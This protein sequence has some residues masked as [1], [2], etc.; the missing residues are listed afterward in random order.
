M[1]PDF[2]RQRLEP[3]VRRLALAG[4]PVLLGVSGGADSVALLCALTSLSRRYQ[5]R[6]QIAHVDHG[7]R[8]E[9]SRADDRFVADL[10]RKFGWPFH[11]H[12]CSISELAQRSGTGIEETA[13]QVRYTFLTRT[14]EA[15]Q[16]PF[17]AVAHTR[18]DQVE[19][20]LHH[21]LRGTGL[22]GLSGMPVS[23]S[24]S[25]G[26]R[27]LRPLLEFQREE[28][29]AYLTAIGQRYCTDETNADPGYTRNRLRH[30]LLP[31]L[32][33]EYNPQIDQCLWQLGQ[34]SQDL[35]RAIRSAATIAL[36]EAQE[37]GFKDAAAGEV[38]LRLAR[39][40]SLSM[41]V[42]RELF[43]LLWQ[44]QGWPAQE[45]TFTHWDQLARLVHTPGQI[46]LPGGRIA[47]S[48]AGFAIR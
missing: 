30:E 9:A 18:G 10:A 39:L 11:L 33:A 20:I 35:L 40:K 32:R 14:A 6:L 37:T 7:L 16:I 25:D 27:L 29:L 36:Q 8:G 26:V 5:L 21:L 23:R 17:V 1:G 31:Q 46:T 47:N 34:Q 22:A 2:P 28:L 44:R 15:E 41:A 24:L 13:R 45:M 3:V 48:S 19:T 42:C 38:R 4:Q 12:T 43:V